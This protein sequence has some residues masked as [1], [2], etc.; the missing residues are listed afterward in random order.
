[1]KTIIHIENDG[2]LTGSQFR[3]QKFRSQESYVS[4]LFWDESH[5]KMPKEPD[6]ERRGGDKGVD[7]R[8]CM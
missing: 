7:F 5:D 6:K 4:D 1:M 2:S 8:V 3:R